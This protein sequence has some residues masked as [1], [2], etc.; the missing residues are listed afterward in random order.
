MLSFVRR[1]A[2]EK[3]DSYLKKIKTQKLPHHKTKFKYNNEVVR[4]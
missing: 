2:G 1:A 4:W 3:N